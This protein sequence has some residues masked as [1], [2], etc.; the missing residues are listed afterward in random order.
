VECKPSLLAWRAFLASFLLR[1]RFQEEYGVLGCLDCEVGA[2][3][4]LAT[5]LN[6]TRE[7]H[8]CL[9]LTVALS[10]AILDASSV[11]GIVLRSRFCLGSFL[12]RRLDVFDVSF[13][14]VLLLFIL[15]EV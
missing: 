8:P 4:A 9:A 7:A 3:V 12:W 10:P 6:T 14:L 13:Y 1:S 15:I 5:A 2:L 11:Y